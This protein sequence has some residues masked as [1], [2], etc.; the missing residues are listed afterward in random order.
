MTRLLKSLHALWEHL[1]EAS[2]ENDYSRY[3][4]HV[5]ALGKEPMSFQAFNQL[6]WEHKYSQP[7]RCC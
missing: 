4:A 5:L 6:R 3:Q 7:N 2:G 1:R